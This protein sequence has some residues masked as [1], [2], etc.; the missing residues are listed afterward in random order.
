MRSLSV[1]RGVCRWMATSL[2][3]HQL[4]HLSTLAADP[5]AGDRLSVRFA[6]WRELAG[7]LPPDTTFSS[8]LCLDPVT[9]ALLPRTALS[10]FLA[11]QRLRL[12]ASGTLTVLQLTVAEGAEALQGAAA[13][14][15]GGA[16]P[17]VDPPTG[18]DVLAAAEAGGMQLSET[19]AVQGGL[20]G[21]MAA[22]VRQWRLRLVAHWR[23]ARL[24]GTPDAT[25]RRYA[26]A[27]ALQLNSWADI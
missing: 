11:Q 13:F 17:G 10:A 16:L 15:T 27:S 19:M 25:L 2:S 14:V 20:S 24:C 9:M 18:A 6:G 7:V 1:V 22:S 3:K 12:D 21:H 23:Q 8:I 5:V 26:L 4:E